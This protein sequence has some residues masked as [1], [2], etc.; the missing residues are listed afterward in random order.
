MTAPVTLHLALPKGRM[1]EGVL[2][3]LGDAGVSVRLGARGYRPTV[4]LPNVEA[5]LLKPQNII[6]MLAAGTRD[7]GF[8]GADWVAELG[9]EL[10]E[11]MDTGLDV[12]RLVAAAPEAL[13]PDG[14][15]PDRPVV[16]A[17]EYER[18][19]TR[20][21]Q[22]NCPPGSRFVRSYGATEAFPPED[23]DCIVDN[24]ATGDT[25]RANQ[26]RILGELMRSSTRLY[27][28]QRAWADPERR[29]RIEDLALL[30]RS[31]LEARGRVL[32]EINIDVAGLAGLVEVLPCMREP[33][34]SL[35]HGNSGYAV[36]VAVRRDQL[37]ALI[38]K[39]RARGGTD[40]VVSSP[41]QIVP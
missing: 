28:S 13:V 38:P 17:S 34:I 30:L 40:I 1:Q 39:I 5:K 24:T 27:A 16:V 18:L 2:K 6:E 15:L 35:L 23:A 10:V 21:L 33:T 29:A 41:A 25:L 37:P 4:G 7:L 14:I 11:V 20:W 12:V 31:V 19:T 8:A 36:K 3:L 26:L 32:V 9:V 22:A